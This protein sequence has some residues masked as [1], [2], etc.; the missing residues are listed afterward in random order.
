[1]NFYIQRALAAEQRILKQGCTVV[2]RCFQCGVDMAGQVPFEYNSNHF[3][4]MPCLKEHRLRNKV[5]I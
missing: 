1:M 2:S 3:C 4:S 5:I